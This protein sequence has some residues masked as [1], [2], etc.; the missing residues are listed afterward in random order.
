M[1][2]A[3]AASLVHDVGHGMFSHAFEEVG[4]KLGLRLAQHELVTEH[5]IRDSEISEAMSHSLGPG[6]P[7]EVATLIGQGGPQTL[8][9]AVVSSQFDADR[10][11]YMQ[12]DR[13][14][15]GVQNSGIDFAWLIENLEVGTVSEVVDEEKSGDIETFVLGPKAIHAAETF[16]L[17][18]FQLY[19][20]IYFHKATRA[21]EKV[22]SALIF[23]V[24]ELCGDGLSEKSGLPKNHPVVLFALNP[25]SMSSVLSLDDSVFFG[26]VPMMAEAEDDEIRELARSLQNRTLPKCLD[27][28]TKLTDE[29]DLGRMAEPSDREEAAKK[30]DRLVA[31][32]EEQLNDWSEKNSKGA[33]RILIDRARRSPYTRFQ[34][35][36]GPLNQ[37]RIRTGPNTILDLAEHSP[38]VA[39]IANFELFR[40]YVWPIDGE[41][42]VMVE[43]IVNQVL[44]EN[45][46]G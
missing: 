20:T 9:D 39:A 19:P 30:I 41:S 23:R 25:D 44:K 38:V 2:V 14:M 40:A 34:E 11:D 36:K 13:L 35:A 16:V 46:D 5:L 22:F 8:Y 24:L 37:I 1:Q 17:A 21:A 3:L 6:F 4:R 28:L 10:L 26:A 15:T 42:G 32:I 43:R 29:I 12:R 45:N 31:L 33:P 7:G 18:L 27:I